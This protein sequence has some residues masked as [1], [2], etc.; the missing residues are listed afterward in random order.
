MKRTM[1]YYVC[2]NVFSFLRSQTNILH[3]QK[4]CDGKSIAVAFYNNSITYI[5]NCLTT[6]LIYCVCL[7]FD[8][9]NVQVY[10]YV[11][12]SFIVT[13][14][15]VFKPLNLR[16]WVSNHLI[17]EAGRII[18]LSVRNRQLDNFWRSYKTFEYG[19]MQKAKITV[20]TIFM[21]KSF[22]ASKINL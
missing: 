17:H 1:F 12:K 15:A 13:G 20:G 14:L 19:F 5:S 18:T 6:C 4:K 10:K 9:I 7:T 3:T 16:H 21:E 22:I 8:A 2:T 11:R